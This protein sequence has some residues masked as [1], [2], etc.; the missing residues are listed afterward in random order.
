MDDLSCRI[1]N[2]KL[3]IGT[4]TFKDVD[5]VCYYEICSQKGSFVLEI[6]KERLL[7]ILKPTFVFVQAIN[8]IVKTATF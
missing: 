6:H 8:Q 2:L 7:S 3:K 5:D 1:E 4:C